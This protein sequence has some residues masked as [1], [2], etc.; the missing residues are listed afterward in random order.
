VKVPNPLSEKIKTLRE[1]R[2]W[3]QLD[4]ATRLGVEQSTVSRWERD[5]SRPIGVYLNFLER[6][7]A[8]RRVRK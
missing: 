5:I 7:L 3:T 4:L 1:K 8:G 2:G 6:L